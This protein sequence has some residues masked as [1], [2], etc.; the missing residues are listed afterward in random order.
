MKP[1]RCEFSSCYWMPK[2]EPLTSIYYLILPSWKHLWS[3][4][5]NWGLTQVC[6]QG[7]AVRLQRAITINICNMAFTTCVSSLAVLWMTI[8]W[9]QEIPFTYSEQLWVGEMYELV[10]SEITTC[11]VSLLLPR[12][13]SAS[14]YFLN[15]FG[16]RSIYSLIL[17]Q[18]NG[19]RQLL[20]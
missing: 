3:E 6:P 19:K 12:V 1:A 18:D 2:K 11:I 17:G 8:G 4:W 20:Q 16:L 10:Y 7:S 9:P 13:S 14:W 5:K 15:V